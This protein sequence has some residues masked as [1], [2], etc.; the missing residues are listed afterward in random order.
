[1]AEKGWGGVGIGENRTINL[2]ILRGYHKRKVQYCINHLLKARSISY[3]SLPNTNKH[4]RVRIDTV[5][6]S[7]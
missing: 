7:V 1:M 4:L 2:K 3:H 6:M 5:I